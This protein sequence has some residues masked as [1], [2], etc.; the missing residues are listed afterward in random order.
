VSTAGLTVGI[1][2][3]IDAERSRPGRAADPKRMPKLQ[4]L[5]STM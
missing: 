2:V 4:D 3:D 1:T 5:R